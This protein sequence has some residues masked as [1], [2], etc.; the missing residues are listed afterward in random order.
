VFGLAQIVGPGIG[1]LLAV[2]LGL[3]AT[4]MIAGVGSVIALTML[5][6]VLRRAPEAAGR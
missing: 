2:S 5:A 6:W 4:F 1:G 3:R